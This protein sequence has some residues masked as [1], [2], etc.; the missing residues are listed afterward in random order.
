MLF[1]PSAVFPQIEKLKG[2][3]AEA[4]VADTEMMVRNGRASRGG[5]DDD[6]DDDDSHEGYGSRRRSAGAASSSS[7][8]RRGAAAGGAAVGGA[9]AV[10]AAAGPQIDRLKAQ[11]AQLQLE[12]QELK[13]KVVRRTMCLVCECGPASS[14]GCGST[15][16]ARGGRFWIGKSK[17][18]EGRIG[19]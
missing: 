7:A 17:Q 5:V 8:A 3:L 16:G 14:R 15:K 10:A 9:A 19:T 12:N 11:V 1:D 18:G 2:L 13:D 6:D 4:N